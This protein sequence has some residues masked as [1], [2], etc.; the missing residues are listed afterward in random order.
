MMCLQVHVED[1]QPEWREQVGADPLWGVEPALRWVGGHEQRE[2]ATFD[3]PLRAPDWPTQE[4][5][6][7]EWQ[8]HFFPVV[9]VSVNVSVSVHLCG[10]AF[11][12][13]VI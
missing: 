11:S 10:A 12:D 4:G 9:S 6:V 13:L 7:C 5:E 2:A 1:H 3:P 8:W